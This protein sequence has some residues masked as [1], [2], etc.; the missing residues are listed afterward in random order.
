M[1]EMFCEATVNGGPPLSPV[2]VLDS[3]TAW[4]T[5]AGQVAE[6]AAATGGAGAAE[7]RQLASA[8]LVGRARAHLQAGRSSEAALD[9]RAVPAGFEYSLLYSNDPGNL[10][11]TG[12]NVW[13]ITAGVRN[14]LGVAPPF[15][16][17]DD[18]RMPILPPSPERPPLDGVT[19]YWTQ[20][21]YESYGAPIRLA[22][23][24]EAAYLLAEATGPAAMLELIQARRAAAEQPTYEGPFDDTSVL[25]EFMTQ[26]SREFY[27]EGKAMG[28]SRRHPQ[29]VSYLP[30]PGT[31][32]P[33]PGYGAVGNQ[34]CWPLPLTETQNNPHFR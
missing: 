18:P 25:A 29:A 16:I 9:A 27:L 28:D 32:F 11:R 17:L 8:A 22:S 13:G 21:K 1:G 20:A 15:R 7:A 14:V 31:P 19:E 4:F 34:I 12:N 2:M 3:A 10:G 5:L 30:V 6:G 33:K 26:R 23:S 24:I